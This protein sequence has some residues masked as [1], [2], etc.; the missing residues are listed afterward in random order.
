[1]GFVKDLRETVREEKL[2]RGRGYKDGEIG[3]WEQFFLREVIVV[4]IE[5]GKWG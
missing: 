2:E 1:M 4:W 5:V 3:I